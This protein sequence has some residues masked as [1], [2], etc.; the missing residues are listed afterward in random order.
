MKILS[1]IM[2]VVVVTLFTATLV[3]GYN[4]PQETQAAFYPTGAGTYYLNSP[5]GS[6]ESTLTLSSFTEP[7]SNI[8]YTMSYLNSSIE[9]G[10][11]DAQYPTKTEFISFT[12]ITQNSNNTATLTGVSR[13]LE[14]SYPFI[15]STTMAVGHSGQSIFVLSNPPQIYQQYAALQNTQTITG[16][17]SF[18]VPTSPSNAA[19]KSY[20]DGTVFGGIG[21]AT[22]S[23]TGTVQIATGA[24][25]AASTK[26][27]SIGR[28]VIPASIATSTYNLNTSV[29]IVP[30][31]GSGGTI[32]PNF[33]DLTHYT[34]T[35][36]T[37][38][39]LTF[40]NAGDGSDG[41]VT[42]TNSTTTLSRDMYYQNLTLTNGAIITGNWRIFVNGTISG[43][44]NI[45]QNGSAGSAGG[46]NTANNFGPGGAAINGYFTTP[47]GA[48]G[49]TGGS[50]PG[51]GNNG[52]VGY[53]TI[54]SLATTTMASPGG[55]GSA[56]GASAGGGAGSMGTATTTTTRFG[57]IASNTYD[58]IDITTQ[59][60]GPAGGGGGGGGGG[61][62]SGN[63]G[64]GGGG[65]GGTGGFVYIIAKN[66]TATLNLTAIG[67]GGGAGG[68][69]SGTA[70]GNGGGGAGGNGGIIVLVSG[71][72]PSTITVNNIGGSGGGAGTGGTNIATAGTAGLGGAFYY[73][74]FYN[75]TR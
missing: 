48:N 29:N 66:V 12:G 4:V 17:W 54:S 16:S 63:L 44:G 18:P 9:Y 40:L 61:N 74:P 8:P 41:N 10:T 55:A 75:L 70:L 20:V 5:I 56:A 71:N 43:N 21:G 11:I 38:S 7:I 34:G 60:S 65:A 31:T 68:P 27:G 13:G 49:G 37:S 15:A 69:G 23:A 57:K 58:G 30:V 72:N 33:I 25:A 46:G 45:V 14:R 2:K 19:T 64:G 36:G 1:K 26:N 67:G 59:N 50:G 62:S 32:D 35:I 28:L 42:I 51:A 3:V 47:A 39:N 73:V 53:S 52:S 22:E 24:Q 6:T